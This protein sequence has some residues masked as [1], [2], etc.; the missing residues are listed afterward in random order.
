MKLL[1]GGTFKDTLTRGVNHAVSALFSQ[2][3]QLYCLNFHYISKFIKWQKIV[4]ISVA[5]THIF[6]PFSFCH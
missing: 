6:L 1:G 4:S 5:S 3:A 2:Q